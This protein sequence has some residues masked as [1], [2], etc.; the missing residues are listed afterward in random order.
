MTWKCFHCG[1]EVEDIKEVKCPKCGKKILTKKRAGVV[2]EIE[3]D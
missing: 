3:T 2:K 1:E